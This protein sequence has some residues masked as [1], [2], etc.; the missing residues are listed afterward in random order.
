MENLKKAKKLFK[1]PALS[2]ILAW[3]KPVYWPIVAVSTI[4][5]ISALLSLGLTLVTKALVDAATGG[6][7]DRLWQFGALMVA[8]YAIQ[9]GMSVWTS[10]LQIRLAIRPERKHTMMNREQAIAYGKRIGVRYHIYNNHGCLVGGTRTL[11]DAQA[12]KKRFEMKDRKNPWARG[13]TRFEI[14]EAN[15]K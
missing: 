10:F 11:E 8:L 9:R 13:T 15:A 7:L 12:M 1:S 2:A 3:A 6:N 4:S 5:V 14:R